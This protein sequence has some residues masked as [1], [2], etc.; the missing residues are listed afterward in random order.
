[1]AQ[2]GR[3]DLYSAELRQAEAER[4]EEREPA[5]QAP[6]DS[7]RDLFAR[8]VLDAQA[9]NVEL[10]R[11]DAERKSAAVTQRLENKLASYELLFKAN[12]I[13]TREQVEALPDGEGGRVLRGTAMVQ[14]A[15]RL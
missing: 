14:R 3:A 8:T 6:V 9:A 11:A 4:A 5:V 13:R 7:A 2:D 1:M 10:G 12:N 15:A